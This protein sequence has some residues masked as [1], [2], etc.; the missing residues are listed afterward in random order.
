MYQEI[1]N[2]KRLAGEVPGCLMFT[3]PVEYFDVDE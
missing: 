1:V 2:L 3:Y